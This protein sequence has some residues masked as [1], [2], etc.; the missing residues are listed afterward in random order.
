MLAAILETELLPH[1]Q[2]PGRYIGGELNRTVK[3][4]TALDV[5]LALAFPDVYEVGMSHLGFKILYE[6][7]NSLDWACAERAF[8]PWPD[9]D[10][11]MRER[12]VPL[13]T[14]ETF[15]L[16]SDFDLVG[17]SLQYELCATNV[18]HMLDLAGIPRT[19]EE[20]LER[21]GPIILAGGPGAFSCEALAPYLDAVVLGDGEVV[22]VE[23]LKKMREAK[24]DA[25]VTRSSSA[26][27]AFLHAAAVSVGG[28]YVPQ[29]YDV[30]YEVSGAVR[31]IE[32]AF[33]DLPLPIE[34]TVVADLDAAPY[35][36]APIV[37]LINVV[38]D[39]AV[40]EV[41]RGCTQGCRFCQAGIIYR[42][43]RERRLETL[44]DQGHK[45]LASTGLEELSLASLS[46]GDYSRIR[47]LVTTLANEL[48]ADATSIALPSLRIDT[49]SVELAEQVA[50]IKRTGITFAPETGSERLRAV[51]N[52]S[53]HDNE[54]LEA[55]T[56]AYR[57]GWNLI[58]LYFMI[59][60]PTETDEDLDAIA[61]LI[62]RV[63]NARRAHDGRRGA[64]NV[65]VSCFV[66]KAH[67][68]F[69]WL[70]FRPLEE[71]SEK[72]RYLRERVRSKAIKLRFHDPKQSYL[73]A[74]FSRGDR[75]LASVVAEAVRLGARFDDWSEHF[76]F[77]RW[78]Q[79]FSGVDVNPNAYAHR[80]FAL[81]AML[82]W[83]HLSP[84]VDKAYLLAEL[85]RARR[86]EFT[87]DCRREGC[88]LCGSVCDV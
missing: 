7:V 87:P 30:T 11:R 16:L 57:R 25:D 12:G 35:P 74:V 81:D 73:E 20:R 60:L 80:A 61:V 38:H 85:D 4:H 68:P 78:L 36:T 44:L 46:T 55:A 65:A 52:K 54:L 45:I 82:P 37:P 58:K 66:P 5:T 50:R 8:A 14:L 43:V 83:D 23:I 48:K 26:R 42:P 84:R 2:K 51:I 40:V 71:F 15:T 29:F 24:R 70:G 77:E 88:R 27:R 63:S 47:E 31:S 17:F 56:E 10:E 13:H 69:Q 9:M 18:L 59:G 33:D 79:A 21:G 62:D 64:V 75:R 22:I 49:Y 3:D 86:G 34:R 76:R 53:V 41:M 39:R 72:I 19:A 28:V 67:T 6:I 1:V 32:R